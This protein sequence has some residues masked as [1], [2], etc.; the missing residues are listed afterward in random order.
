M[1]QI[2]IK[3]SMCDVSNMRDPRALI[4]VIKCCHW[5]HVPF[6][7]VCTSKLWNSLLHYPLYEFFS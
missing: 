6:A 3:Y 7:S 1:L 2:D 4:W 5:C